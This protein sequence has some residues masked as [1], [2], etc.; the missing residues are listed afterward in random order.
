MK[1]KI[2]ESQ[3]KRFK[4]LNE[5]ADPL[6]QFEKLC[7]IKI[8]EINKLYNRVT[9]LSIYEI[10]HKEMDMASIYSLLDKIENDLQMGDRDA[11]AYIKNRPEEDLDL[12]IDKAH[13]NVMNRLT[14]LQLIVMDLEKLQLSTEEHDLT[15]AFKDIKPIDISG[16]Q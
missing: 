12:R 3:A 2:T 16:L 8:Q 10:L 7:S 15:K 6:S 14:P 11:Y 5:N 13:D 9:A 1:I 4:L